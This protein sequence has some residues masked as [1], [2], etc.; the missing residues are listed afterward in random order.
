MITYIGIDCIKYRRLFEA[1]LGE[2]GSRGY[3]DAKVSPGQT[4]IIRDAAVSSCLY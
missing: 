2:L 1:N 3:L 4:E